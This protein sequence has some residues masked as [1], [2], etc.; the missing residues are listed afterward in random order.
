MANYDDFVFAGHGTSEIT[1]GYDPGATNGSTQEH[2]LAESIAKKVIEYKKLAGINSHYDE[3]N[4]TDVDLKGNT[5]N[6]KC[7][8]C[9]H[10]NAGGG[11]GAE[12]FVP[13]NEKFL[14]TDVNIL[15]RL[16]NEVGLK[17]RGVK[18]RDY[19]TEEYKLRT[20]GKS[21]G[22]MDYYKEIREAWGMG[23]SLS[24][25]EVGFIDTADLN[26]IQKNIDK[27]ALIIAE[28]TAK[29]L[30]KTIVIPKPV[31]PTPTTPS[32]DK[33]IKRVIVNG[34]Q[35]GAY[36]NN[37]NVIQE[38]RKALENKVTKIEIVRL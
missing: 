34:K 1:G 14:D 19:N 36:S 35:V 13:L 24:L 27:I 8:V 10:I 38:V 22:G 37:D 3:N 12:I 33:A 18:S 15:N 9:I 26:I 25:I 5:Y 11:Q 21:I 2:I 32:T 23:I 28:E 7:G 4:Y 31:A 30:G 29:L 17:N 20:N 6:A 16:Q